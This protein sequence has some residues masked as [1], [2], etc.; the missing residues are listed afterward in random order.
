[1]EPNE[2]Y[3]AFGTQPDRGLSAERILSQRRHFG[4]NTA[5]IARRNN[6]GLLFLQQFNNAFMYLLIGAASVTGAA[7]LFSDAADSAVDAFVIMAVVLASALAGAIQ[8]QKANQAVASL[9]KMLLLKASVVRDGMHDMILVEELVPGDLVLLKTGN[10]VPA[11]IRIISAAGFK[12]DESAVTGVQGVAHKNTDIPAGGNLPVERTN[13]AFAGSLVMA[14]KATGIVVHTGFNTELGQTEQ[15]LGSLGSNE[16]DT[17]LIQKVKA[18]NSR[19]VYLVLGVSALTLLTG[20]WRSQSVFAAFEEA[21]ALAVAAAPEG[22]IAAIT[23]IMAT[24]V[25][26]MAARN[27]VIK[28]LPAAETLGSTTVI[29]T[30]K[31]GVLTE[32]KLTLKRLATARHCY[33]MSDGLPSGEDTPFA[34]CL[35]AS[36]LCNDAIVSHSTK[37]VWHYAGSPADNAVFPLATMAGIRPHELQKKHPRIGEIPF[38]SE[39]KYMAT[40]HSRGNGSNIVYVKGAIEKVLG[41]CLG[42]MTENGETAPIR[43][44]ETIQKAHSLATEGLRVIA[45]AYKE[46]PEKPGTAIGSHM[47]G[48]FVFMGLMAFSDPLR[49]EVAQAVAKCQQ[50]GI[51]IKLITN[52]HPVSALSTAKTLGISLDSA[53]GQFTEAVTGQQFSGFPKHLIG[54]IT[55]KTA[56][57]GRADP[58]HKYEVVERLRENGH[59]VAVT[60]EGANDVP[61]LLKA[62]IGIAMKSSTDAAKEAA[63]MVLADDNF[64]SVEAAVEEG[65]NIDNNIKKFLAWTLPTNLGEGLVILAALLAGMSLPILPVQLLWINTTTALLLGLSLAFE[66]KEKGMMLQQPNNPAAPVLGMGIVRRLFIIAPI[67]IVGAFWIYGFETTVMGATPEQ[68]RTVAVNVFVAVE[69]FYLFNCRTL[70]APITSV[71]F[72]SNKWLLVGVALMAL[73]Q[74]F[75]TYSPFMNKYFHSAPVSGSAWL[76]TLGLGVGT[77]V[78]VEI[79]K[80]LFNRKPLNR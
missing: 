15:H 22:L 70:K 69:M 9:K 13:M 18:V 53:P 7:A 33:E 76:M 8:E 27:A 54:E 72:F 41:L 78:V 62:H 79:E 2:L 12:V 39:N 71:G 64:T 37:G 36:I 68:A 30:E 65:R 58:S 34:A 24:G 38:S 77:L 42:E 35:N 59:I 5:E 17:P 73:L 56:V 10:K 50:A 43:E 66:P 31:S 19:M 25:R 23:I 29:C 21:L 28:N 75:Y 51:K 6:F 40:M 46:V 14:G 74:L 60:G 16:F 3:A 61:A 63:D 57:F 4:M 52:D 44:A 45:L 47:N 1:M 20:L 26:R 80:A 32:N 11:D 49:P 67:M 55:E 48:G